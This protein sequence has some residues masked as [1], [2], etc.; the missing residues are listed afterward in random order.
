MKT[1]EHSL[2]SRR[3]RA[4]N[5]RARNNCSAPKY[6]LKDPHLCRHCLVKP[7]LGVESRAHSCTAL[8]QAVQRGQRSTHTRQTILN[9]RVI[10]MAV[11][12]NE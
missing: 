4:R 10:T 6:L 1:R 9:L 2:L 12:A 8:S 3:G 7:N 11:A 5:K